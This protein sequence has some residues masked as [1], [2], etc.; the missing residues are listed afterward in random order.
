MH[1][2]KQKPTARIVPVGT[3][4]SPAKTSSLKIYQ[5]RY[6]GFIR[7][8]WAWNVDNSTIRGIKPR[9][10]AFS[11]VPGAVLRGYVPYGGYISSPVSLMRKIRLKV[12]VNSGTFHYS[13]CGV[14]GFNFTVNRYREIG[15]RAIPDVMIAFAMP[16]KITAMLQ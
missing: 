10:G 15:N 2:Y 12:M 5:E 7:G 1:T 14:A 16:L 13:V 11:R 9:G 4:P 3:F 6:N 8:A